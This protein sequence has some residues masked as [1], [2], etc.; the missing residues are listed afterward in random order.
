M[1]NTKQR[2]FDK[3]HIE[4]IIR[5][6]K[7]VNKF[8]ILKFRNET[9]DDWPLTLDEIVEIAGAL[10]ADPSKGIKEDE[11]HFYSVSAQSSPMPKK[12]W[13]AA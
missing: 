4:R 6:Q 13:K 10:A 5:K 7:K 2:E 9:N 3:A 11:N 1:R 12:T 8:Q